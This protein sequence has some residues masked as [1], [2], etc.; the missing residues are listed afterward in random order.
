M[1]R[2]LPA[3]AALILAL[4][5]ACS[6]DAPTGKTPG[7][8]QQDIAPKGTADR[9][10]AA[11]LDRLGD[12][13]PLVGVL[14]PRAWPAVHAR[15][16]PLA[17]RLPGALGADFARWNGL[18]SALNAGLTAA[19]GGPVTLEG[20][21]PDRA[22]V[23]ALFEPAMHGPPGSTAAGMRHSVTRASPL[24]LLH[25]TPTQPAVSLSHPAAHGNPLQLLNSPDGSPPAL[26]ASNAASSGIKVHPLSVYGPDPAHGVATAT[27]S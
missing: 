12:G 14:D 27:P 18:D 26:K 11:L 24:S 7:T 13:A 6:G 20:L 22:I 16:Q 19:L 21:D 9:G 4:S 25:R 8:Q 15:L 3:F 5:A 1:R 17:E 2:T 23:F 10:T